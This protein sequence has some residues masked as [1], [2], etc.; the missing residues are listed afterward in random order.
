M[1]RH[2]LTGVLV[3]F[4]VVVMVGVSYAQST[5]AKVPKMSAQAKKG[6]RM[7]LTKP[8]VDLRM[9]MR[10]LWEDHITWT[11]NYIISSLSDLEDGAK[12]CGETA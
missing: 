6:D 9:A 8:A 3:A 5:E 4:V 11:R 12:M 10:K 2:I 7:F 1:K